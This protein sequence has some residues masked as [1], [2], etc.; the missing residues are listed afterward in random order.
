MEFVRDL[1]Y[2]N[3]LVLPTGLIIFGWTKAGKHTGFHI[4][5]LSIM[6]DAGVTTHEHVNYVFV[7]HHH[8]DHILRIVE[9]LLWHGG[10]SITHIYA[11]EIEPIIHYFEG[12]YDLCYNKKVPFEKIKNTFQFD[13]TNIHDEKS[14]E[15][16]DKIKIEIFKGYHDVTSIGYGIVTD[17]IYHLLYFGDTNINA[18][19]NT[20]DWKKYKCIMI[21]CTRFFDKTS[22][23]HICWDEIKSYILENKNIQFILMHISV[24]ENIV[25]V[26]ALIDKFKSDNLINNVDIW[27]N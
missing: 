11:P 21:E 9:T 12:F 6:L 27:H 7:T 1:E 23:F 15:L 26:Q 18:L 14:F 8:P 16:N 3:S 22:S 5:A 10:K 19:K 4:P 25:N 2:C 13:I 17:N 24:V 20:N